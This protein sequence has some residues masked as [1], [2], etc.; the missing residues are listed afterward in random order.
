MSSALALVNGV[1]RTTTVTA[2]LPAIYDQTISIV[3]SGGSPPGTVNGPVSSGTAL[4]LP[5]SGTY[6]VSSGV[7][8]L[9]IYLN[10]ERLEYTR[11]WTTSG[12]GPNYTQF[13]LSVGLVIYDYIDLRI[14]RNS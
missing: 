13:Q 7:P 10:G 6:T 12:S 9:T 11:D 3:A 14:E 4:T 1:P 5:S 2:S 8:N